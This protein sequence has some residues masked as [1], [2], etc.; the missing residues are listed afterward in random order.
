[1]KKVMIAYSSGGTVHARF[2][3]CM[4]ELV[5]FELKEP[6]PEYEIVRVLGVQGLYIQE[7]RN[8]AAQHAL[9][10]GAEWLLQLDTDISFYPTLL[11][12]LMRNASHEN[13]IISGLYANIG[14]TAADGGFDIVNCVYAEAQ[15]GKYVP[16]APPKDMQPFRVDAAGTGV[17]LTHTDVFRRMRPPWYF[18][19]Q[20]VNSDGSQQ[21][22]NEDLSFC[23]SARLSG[24]PIL[25]DPLADVVHWKTLP[26]LSSQFR[27]MYDNAMQTLKMVKSKD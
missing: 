3:Q 14:N 17:F 13:P 27:D 9:D 21:L 12:T 11:R 1:M 20:F 4:T 16:M 5:W 6:S 22:M 7:N 19:S 2:A 26:L 18:L 23:R 8:M 25:C 15:D 24:Y 10:S